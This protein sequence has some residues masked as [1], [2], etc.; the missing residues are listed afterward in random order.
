MGA[1]DLLL[2]H[3]GLHFPSLG[4]WMDPRRPVA[5]GDVAVITHAHADHVA[6]H[7]EVILTEPT[8]RLMHARMHGERRE[9]VLPFHSPANLLHPPFAP[10]RDA[11]LT[12]LP[13]GH[14]LGSAMP[15][16]HVGN[17]SV[18]YTGDFKLRAG[19]SAEPC[20]PCHADILVMETTFGRPHYLFPPARDV[21]DGIIRFCH[22]AIANDEVPVLLGYSLGKSQEILAALHHQNLP[23]MLADPVARLTRIYEALGISFPPHGPLA[24]AKARGHVVL[25]PPGGNVPALRRRLGP[26]RVAILSGWAL[27]PG[28]RFRHHAD[29]AFP[30]SDHADF[31]ELL[32]MV[33]LVAPRKV[34]TLHGF[35]TDFAAHLRRLGIEAWALEASDQLDLPLPLSP[36]PLRAP[37]PNPAPR[38]PAPPLPAALPPQ[39]DSLAAMADACL[40]IRATPSK[41]AK[42]SAL[43]RFLSSI[44]H[45][46]LPN[47][48]AWFSG[49]PLP[50]PDAPGS[51]VG[52]TVLRDAICTAAD[53]S[54]EAFHGAHLLHGDTAATAADLLRDQPGD[55]LNRPS[56]EDV[57]RLLHAI[58]LP[59]PTVSR[60][61]LLAAFLRRCNP[62]EALHAVK[63]LAGNLRIGLKEGLVEESI[64]RAFHASPDAVRRAVMLLG[65]LGAV[66]LMA[67]EQR[68]H[69]AAIA[70][71]QPL[72]VMLASPEPS[73]AA[74]TSR[75]ASW[76]GGIPAGAWAED[77]HDGIRCQAHAFEGT[78]RLFSRDLKDIT[79]SF[80]DIAATLATSGKPFILDGEIMAMDGPRPL[81]FASLQRRLGRRDPDLFMRSE[82]PVAFVAFDLLWSDHVPLIDLPFS[83]RRRLLLAMA[84]ALGLH[85][86][87][88]RDVRDADAVRDAFDDARA[89]G[90]EGLVI[91]DPAAPYQPGRR[92]ISWVKL[93]Q[94]M[95]TLDCVLVGAEYGHG[96][97]SGVLSDYTFSLRDPD[98]GALRVVGKAYSGLT[99]A[100]IETLTHHLLSKVTRRIGRLHEV[101]PDTVLEI[102][103]DRIQRSARHDSGLALR[104][105]RIVR[106]R[107]DK[108]PHECDTLDAARALLGPSPA[109]TPP[110]HTAD[111][112]R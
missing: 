101:E 96:R 98:T 61:D 75:M 74:V 88:G 77:K 83:E 95:P 27:D 105:P 65:D 64:A 38:P 45:P 30:L 43:A 80:P 48:V 13:A 102:A 21:L 28:C 60:R 49:R 33:R 66:A 82:V 42:I 111:G 31:A 32:E 84:S 17:S 35:A 24:P 86:A 34:F 22:E 72:R 3:G 26:S 110:P 109:D 20:S 62:Q 107:H 79:R 2:K 15:L 55:A 29:A 57:V 40:A 87:H 7:P 56:L 18:L 100:E 91:K 76:Q 50:G 12:L 25:A 78:A 67:R 6:P 51:P 94:A 108:Q 8:R 99:D 97:R 85:V 71:F 44:P 23:I 54:H 89:R 10:P 14:V 58:A 73:P 68:L 103:F 59:Q 81:P 53:A 46:L 37:I 9:H 1:A 92:G 11:T 4:L 106:V 69:Q 5:H 41:D 104:F 70:P 19:L 16:L 52:W 93:K 90:H 36:A 112:A 63:V 39:P 47:V